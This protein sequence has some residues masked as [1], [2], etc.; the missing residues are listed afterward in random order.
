MSPYSRLPLCSD[1]GCARLGGGVRKLRFSR[2]LCS[3]RPPSRR[4]LHRHDRRAKLRRHFV[5][6]HF[7]KVR[8]S[9]TTCDKARQRVTKRDNMQQSATTCDKARQRATK[10]DKARQSVTK[11]DNDWIFFQSCR[12]N[13]HVS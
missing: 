7:D 2:N 6:L 10:R 13:I 11:R 12:T 5:H 9:A 8:Q 1:R 3:T 4:R